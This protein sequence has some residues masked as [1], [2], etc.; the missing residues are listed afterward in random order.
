MKRVELSNG[1][2][3]HNLHNCSP[4]SNF[5]GLSQTSTR[6]CEGSNYVNIIVY[7][8]PVIS[9]Y[10]SPIFKIVSKKA[11]RDIHHFCNVVPLGIGTAFR[12]VRQSN[13]HP[14]DFI[15]RRAWHVHDSIQGQRN[16]MH[17]LCG[18]ACHGLK[19]CHI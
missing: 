14:T 13:E 6:R 12:P 18:N 7:A 17:S 8:S 9:L 16:V 5:F 15:M 19:H 10:L 1:G 11:L 4:S 2:S 3:K